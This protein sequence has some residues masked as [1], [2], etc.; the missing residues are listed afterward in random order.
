M[1][2]GTLGARAEAQLAPMRDALRDVM[3]GARGLRSPHHATASSAFSI[4]A[5]EDARFMWETLLVLDAASTLCAVVRTPT[6]ATR[7]SAAANVEEG[8]GG[9]PANASTTSR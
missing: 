8:A 7:N 4:F 9:T 6:T 2:L 1:R 3:R 5:S